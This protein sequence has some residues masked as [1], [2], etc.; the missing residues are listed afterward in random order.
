MISM[1][2]GAA[3]A[4]SNIALASRVGDLL[5]DSPGLSWVWKLNSSRPLTVAMKARRSRFTAQ[6]IQARGCGMTS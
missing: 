2:S 5:G 4:S 3:S 1:S 6:Y